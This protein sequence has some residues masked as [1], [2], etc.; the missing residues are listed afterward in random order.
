MINRFNSFFLIFKLADIPV[1]LYVTDK[2]AVSYGIPPNQGIL[3][4]IQKSHNVDLHHKVSNCGLY[5]IIYT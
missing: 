5:K 2:D 1:Y 3:A 4:T